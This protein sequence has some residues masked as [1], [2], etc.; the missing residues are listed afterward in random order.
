MATSENTDSVRTMVPPWVRATLRGDARRLGLTDAAYVRLILV[1]KARN[2]N[3]ITATPTKDD[4]D[5]Q[6]HS[7]LRLERC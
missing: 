1:E 2:I 4:H 5:D 7:A 6:A 3:P